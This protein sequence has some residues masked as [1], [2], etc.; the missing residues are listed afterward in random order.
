MTFD[1]NL[2]LQPRLPEDTVDIPGV[3]TIRVRALSRAEVDQLRELKDDN[4]AAERMILAAGLVDPK[5]TEAEVGQWQ[6]AATHGE[7]NAV[8]EV[9]GQLSG[10]YEGADKEAYKSA[11]E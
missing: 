8:A 7:V 2:L 4:A 9:I 5:L 6:Q 11:S 3:G 10:L 1:K